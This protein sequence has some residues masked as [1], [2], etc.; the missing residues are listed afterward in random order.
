MNKPLIIPLRASAQ[1]AAAGTTTGGGVALMDNCSELVAVFDLSAIGQL[2]QAADTLD[3]YIDASHDG[4]VWFN[5]GRFLRITGVDSEYATGT[6]TSTGAL[7]AGEHAQSELVSS[8]A[9]APAAFATS[10]LTSDATEVADG[11]VVV[12]GSAGNERTYRFKDTPSQA[13]DVKRDGTTPGTTLANLKKAVNASGVGDG[14]DY[15][16]GTLVHPTVIAGAI[17]ATTITFWA[18]VIGTA[19][20]TE[21]TTTTA[22][23]LSW[24]DTTLGGGTGASNP[25]VATTSATYTIGSRTYTA[26]LQLAETLGLAAIVDHVL[27]ETSEAVFLDNVKLATNA[28]AGAGT[29]Y[30]TGT[31]VHADVIATTNTDTVQTFVART[32]G[33][34]P[35]TLATTETLG[36]Y[37][38]PDT[39]LG[40]GA[41][42]STPG[43]AGETATIGATTYTWVVALTESYGLS[44]IVNQ[45]LYGG[46]VTAAFANLRKAINASGV[47]G[48]DYSTGTVAN[49]TANSG[50]SDA[51]TVSVAADTIGPDGN[52]VVT[53]E[54]MA[55]GAFGA[56]TLTGGTYG[57]G[58]VAKQALK[59]SPAILES[60]Q[61]VNLASDLSSS[62]GG[63]RQVGFGAYVRYRGIVAGSTPDFTYSVTLVG[64]K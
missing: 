64:K 12:I 46:S 48:T 19:A 24:A 5:I 49:A 32:I 14:S 47:A 59:W 58:V 43:V 29:K 15:F 8:G 1:V 62:S 31:V 27:W 36:N 33:T 30:A 51:T 11:E 53:T 16:S 40:G 23:H 21:A 41:G 57:A 34:A 17:N 61:P 7:T 42:N 39:T 50:A 63:I 20:N 13:Y 38:F 37:A 26:V 28:G 52:S 2:T 45:V 6:L 4:S 55:N 56:A 10:V 35:N 44:A 9:C 18:R 60:S 3:I 22:T 25:G 54:T